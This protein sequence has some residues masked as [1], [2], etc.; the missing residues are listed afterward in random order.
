MLFQH[1][2]PHSREAAIHG[3]GDYQP[4]V[5][6]HVAFCLRRLKRVSDQADQARKDWG[7]EQTPPVYGL[8]HAKNFGA[9]SKSYPIPDGRHTMGQ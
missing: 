5:T 7:R 6:G 1:E 2:A 8:A 4:H 3:P 9:L